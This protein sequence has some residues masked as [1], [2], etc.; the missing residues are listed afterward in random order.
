MIVEISD[1]FL[2]QSN[3]EK[4]MHI[5]IED[6]TTVEEI[7]EM[8]SIKNTN[9]ALILINDKVAQKNDVVSNNDKITILPIC[10]GG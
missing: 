10:G 2:H 8:L 6:K 7:I 5:D 9:Y 3:L 4:V 1:T